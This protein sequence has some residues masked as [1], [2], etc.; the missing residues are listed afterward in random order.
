MP[1]EQAR[2]SARGWPAQLSGDLWRSFFSVAGQDGVELVA[3]ADVELGEAL[4]QVVLGRAR[5][6]EEAGSDRR[7]GQAIAGQ[8]GDLDFPGGELGGH[9]G[10]AFTYSLAGREQLPR[11]SFGETVGSHA[12]RHGVAGAPLLARGGPPCPPAPPPPQV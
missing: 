2:V 7:V 1:T 6:H 4:V 11:G 12:G 10:R 9:I 3:G 5:A 8:P